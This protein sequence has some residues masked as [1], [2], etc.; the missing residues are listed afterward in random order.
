MKEPVKVSVLIPAYNVERYIDQCLESVMNQTLR[1]IEII[2]V[3]DGS[4]DSTL[5]HI[6]AAAEKDSR[7]RVIRHEKNRKTLQSRK[8]AV[9]FSRGEYVMF[10]DSDDYLDPDACRTVYESAVKSGAD[11]LQFGTRFENCGDLPEEYIQLRETG[12]NNYQMF[13]FLGEPLVQNY[14]RELL[15]STV[16]QKAVKGETAKRAYKKIPDLPLAAAE[17][18]YT[19]CI[20]LM[21]SRS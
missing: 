17:D 13:E 20:L 7:I 6:E 14:N 9:L 3:D 12:S 16:T 11:I 1:E 2:V 21:E 8:D 15:T 10:L 5:A 4:T 19:T 18:E